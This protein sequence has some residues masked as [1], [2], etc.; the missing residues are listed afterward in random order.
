MI[1]TDEKKV[2]DLLARN[3]Q[4]NPDRLRKALE[5]ARTRRG[6]TKRSAFD[7]LP[8]FGGRFVRRSSDKK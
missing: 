5:A 4:V 7:I 1:M 2:A 6:T 8:P 3:P